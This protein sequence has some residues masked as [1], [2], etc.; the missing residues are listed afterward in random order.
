MVSRAPESWFPAP[1]LISLLRRPLTSRWAI[2]KTK[3][4]ECRRTNLTLFQP[5]LFPA[6]QKCD[7][8]RLEEGPPLKAELTRDQG[9]QYYRVM[10]TVRRMEL[11][12]DQLYKQKIIR[13]F[14]HLY[15]GQVSIPDLESHDHRRFVSGPE[16]R[17]KAP[18]CS[19]VLCPSQEACAA[20]IEA[21]INPSDHLITAYRAHGYTYTRG[22]SVK[23]ILAELTGERGR[24]RH[25]VNCTHLQHRHSSSSFLLRSE[26][27]RGQGQGR[28]NAHVRAA[29]LRRQRHCGSSGKL[30]RLAF[31]SPSF[32][33]SQSF[34]RRSELCRFLWEPASRSPASTKATTRCV[35][36]STE[37]A[38]PIR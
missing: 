20:G 35:S 21:A 18:A 6:L 23:E 3:E 16:S 24:N 14:C 37:T 29:F 33:S 36:R 22:V 8:H 11:K 31:L 28:F 26:R 32:A 13:G 19:E 34:S 15:D 38:R 25:R 30:E 10:Q 5:S 1:S 12:A 7:V 9:L 27:G 2:T 4:E 17:Q